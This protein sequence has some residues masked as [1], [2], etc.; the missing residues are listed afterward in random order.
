MQAPLGPFWLI[1]IITLIT[2]ITLINLSDTESKNS[3]DVV[4]M[5]SAVITLETQRQET[6]EK[7]VGA[8]F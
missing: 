7:Q 5:C 4:E 2:L 8:F 3:S 1:T 6:E